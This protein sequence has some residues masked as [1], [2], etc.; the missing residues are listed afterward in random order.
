[1]TPSQDPKPPRLARWLLRLRP[2][3][4]RRA[5][6]TADLDEMFA[7]RAAGDGTR[8]AAR[9]YYRDVLSLW[10]WNLSG[11]RLAA[12]VAQDLSHGLRVFRRNPGAVAIAVLGLALAIAVATSIFGLLNATVLRQTGVSDPGSTVRVMR[13]FKDGH[14]IATSWPYADYLTLREHAPMP[15]EASLAGGARLTDTPGAP[16]DAGER[17]RMSFVDEG[18][19]RLFGARPLHGRMLQPVD[20]APGAPAVVVASYGFWLHRL[21]A[22]PA[23]VGRQIWLNG[24]SA[25][26]VG[27]APRSFTG[28]ADQ[29]PAFWA[30]FASY[31]LL[32]QGAPLTGTSTIGVNVY[33][34]IPTG[35]TRAQ[36]EAELGAVAAAAAAP[37]PRLGVTTGVRL[38]SRRL[39]LQRFRRRGARDRR[40]CGADPRQP[41]RTPRLRERREPAARE[42]HRPSA[43][44]RRPPRAGRSTGARRPAARDRKPRARARRRSRRAAAGDLAQSGAGG[45]RP[46]AAHGG[47]DA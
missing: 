39:A 11:T 19:L 25:T 33:G 22:D 3:G 29:P 31:P 12:D 26:I 28:L 43:R 36:A 32:Y 35:G 20:D 17:V 1:M 24:T 16:G 41:R 23:A 44:D 47:H 10:A 5:E 8:L 15:I 30:P 42:R 14:G 21:A 34:R 2:L 13:A 4:R 6:V 7:E 37:E 18:Y 46:P 38:E 45:D 40:H 9:R 27:V